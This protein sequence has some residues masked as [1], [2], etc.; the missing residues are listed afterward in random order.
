MS[1]RSQD[2]EVLLKAAINNNQ[3]ISTKE[4]AIRKKVGVVC[5]ALTLIACFFVSI[6]AQQLRSFISGSGFICRGLP[7]RV[8][9][10]MRLRFE[11]EVEHR[12]QRHICSTTRVPRVHQEQKA[13]VCMAWSHYFRKRC[14]WRFTFCPP[15]RPFIYPCRSVDFDLE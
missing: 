14:C 12:W 4:M 2:K 11:F 10:V 9:V 5:I 3:L 8:S 7:H 13:R 1:S 6:H 15:P